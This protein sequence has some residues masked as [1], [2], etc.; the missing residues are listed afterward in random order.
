[1]KTRRSPRNQAKLYRELF[2]PKV[3]APPGESI[4]RCFDC[5]SFPKQGRSR[6]HCTL[7]GVMVY[8]SENQSCFTRREA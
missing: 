5:T 6:G 7:R 1:M 3:V 8:G 4:P 2:E